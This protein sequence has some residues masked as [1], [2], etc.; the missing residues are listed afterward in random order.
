MVYVL[1]SIILLSLMFGFHY[2]FPWGWIFSYLLSVNIT[3]L[4]LMGYDKFAAKQNF[5][6]VPERVLHLFTFAGGTP[7]AYL[8]QKLFRHK[9]IK[10]SYRMKFHLILF[11]QILILV[12]W[13]VWKY[14]FI[15][16]LHNLYS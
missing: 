5:S 16:T 12:L 1:S 8:S 10:Q 13:L 9:T 15:E 3:M 11:V 7:F 2:Y 6:R 14:G 4:V